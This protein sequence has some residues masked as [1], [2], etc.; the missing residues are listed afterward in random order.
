M[1]MDLQIKDGKPFKVQVGGDATIAFVPEL[2]VPNPV[3]P[4]IIGDHNVMPVNRGSRPKSRDNLM[5]LFFG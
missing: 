1:P 2:G 4:I 3:L 5:V